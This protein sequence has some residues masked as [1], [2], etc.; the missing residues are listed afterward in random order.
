MIT[1]ITNDLI[2]YEYNGD[3]IAWNGSQ[4]ISLLTCGE[5]DTLEQMDEFWEDYWKSL[6][7]MGNDVSFV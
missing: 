7:D 1:Q 2:W 6:F 4:Y 3:E 5:F